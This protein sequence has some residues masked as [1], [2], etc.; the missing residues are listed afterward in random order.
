MSITND[1]TGQTKYWVVVVSRD[2]LERG[3]Q[4]GIVQANHG[5][6]APMKPMNPRDFIVF[7]SPKRQYEGKEP[8]KKFTAI[9]RVKEGEIY[10]G[11]MGGGFIPYRRDV[12]FLPCQEADII[13]LIDQLSFIHNK[14]NWGF[15]FRLGFFEIPKADFETISKEMYLVHSS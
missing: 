9:A 5:Q 8:Y 13:P 15:V 7:Y 14:K 3:K 2:H 11:D 10:Q 4:L 1:D 12:E 6:A